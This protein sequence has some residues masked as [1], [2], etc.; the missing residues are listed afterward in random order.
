MGNKKQNKW[1][2]AV[3]LIIMTAILTA[4]AVTGLTGCSSDARGVLAET[5][6]SDEETLAES[7]IDYVYGIPMDENAGVVTERV[8]DIYQNPDVKSGRISQ[9][10]YNQPVSILQ[11]EEGWARVSLVDGSSGWMKAKYIDGDVSSV[12]GRTY[13]HRI[14]VTSREKSIYSS[15]SGGVTEIEAPMGTEFFTFNSSGDVYEVFLPG[16]KT[17][18][19]KGSG[20]IHIGL[21]E[22]VPVTNADDFASTAL[23]LKGTAYLLNGMSALGIDASGLVYICARINGIDL[24]RSITG[25]MSSGI[26]IEPDNVQAGDLVFLAGVGENEAETVTCV[27]ICIGGGNYIYAGR[28]SGYVT[29]GDIKKNNAEGTIVAARRLFN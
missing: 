28:R 19:I 4:A 20:I 18:W 9:A 1:V 29:I 13:T 16:N 11:R 10:L 14:I 15:P 7:V 5:T 21:G 8:A 6:P 22:K 23:R 12:Y 3:S 2:T 26:E 24:P 17:G 25:Q 27:G